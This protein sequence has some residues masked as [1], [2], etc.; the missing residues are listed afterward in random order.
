[1]NQSPFRADTPVRWLSSYPK[2]GNTWVRFLL[3]QYFFGEARASI[4]IARYIPGIHN[5]PQVRAASP[6]DGKLFV[7]NHFPL[8]PDVP[9]VPGSVCI[10]VVRHPR[11]VIQSCLNYA[12]MVANT[13]EAR[14]GEDERYVRSFLA[15]GGAP[16]YIAKRFGTWDNHYRTW[17]DQQRVPTVLV[18]YE[19]MKAHPAR[20][21]T[22]MVEFLGYSPEPAKIESAVALS[23]FERLQALEISEKAGGAD[24]RLFPGTDEQM[25]KGRLFM[26]KGQS[27]RSLDTIAPGLDRAVAER[28]AEGIARFGY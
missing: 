20:E 15:A 10:Y 2:S 24:K 6:F 11:D 23:S 16:E 22:R 21:L 1:M 3:Y 8:G 5:M 13:P 17:L 4:D 14:P 27:G 18:R 9:A 7:K 28:F 25:K 12:R 26:N 19:D